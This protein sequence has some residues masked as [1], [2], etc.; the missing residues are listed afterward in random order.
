VEDELLIHRTNHITNAKRN[1]TGEKCSHESGFSILE[2]TISL[3]LM[4]IVGLGTASAFYYS[5]RN[6][7]SAGNRELAMAVAQQ[8]MEQLRTV[9]MSDA[10]LAATDETSTTVTSSGRQY[11]VLKTIVNSNEV[12][13]EPTVKTITIR[14]TPNSDTA[15]WATNITSLFGSVTLVAQRTALTVGPNRAL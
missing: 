2:T 7:D 15:S 14:V 1:F 11:T 10:S 4:A 6:T 8:Q 3:V 5:F 12:N 13:G 9:D